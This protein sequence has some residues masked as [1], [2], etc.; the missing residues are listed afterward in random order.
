MTA[1]ARKRSPLTTTSDKPSWEVNKKSNMLVFLSWGVLDAA[2][3]VIHYNKLCEMEQSIVAP[4][5]H[6]S[7]LSSSATLCLR[8]RTI[9]RLISCNVHN[10]IC[11][12]S[13]LWTSCQSWW[14]GQRFLSYY[15]WPGRS[16]ANL[17]LQTSQII[18]AIDIYSIY[19]YV[20][21]I[22][23]TEWIILACEA[24]TMKVCV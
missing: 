13:C 21:Q 9:M 19:M 18:P 15:I 2:T 7:F 3:V 23:K 22:L 1:P 10:T 4:D 16:I 20:W 24:Q 12:F 6:W 5:A 11:K 8:G 14:S 17:L